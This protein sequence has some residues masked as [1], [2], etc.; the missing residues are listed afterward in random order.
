MEAICLKALARD[1]ED[2]F[3]SMEQ[4]QHALEDV[5]E[6]RELSI[7]LTK[8]TSDG[9]GHNTLD[10]RRTPTPYPAAETDTEMDPDTAVE[11]A[12][13]SRMVRHPLFWVWSAIAVVIALLLAIIVESRF[14]PP[15]QDGPPGGGP[16]RRE[17]GRMHFAPP[18]PDQT[19]GDVLA[20]HDFNGDQLL[21]PGEFP[22]HIIHRADANGDEWLDLQEL[23]NGYEAEGDELYRPPE[24]GEGPPGGRRPPGGE[25]PRGGR[26]P[27]PGGRRPPP[28]EPGGRGHRPDR[29]PPR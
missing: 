5:L 2:R 17:G 12:A 8:F 18:G 25:R 6:G 21:D 19:P 11:R 29:P 9:R 22:K 20:E 16:G 15:P 10:L 26:R 3:E 27:P 4:F 13:I 7:D 24:P 14:R 28:G 23:Q 1:P